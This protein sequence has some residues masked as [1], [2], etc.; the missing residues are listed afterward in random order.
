MLDTTH[1]KANEWV[2]NPSKVNTGL[3]LALEAVRVRAG[4]PIHIH[5]AWDD[6]GHA[7]HSYHYKGM[8]VDF[9][10]DQSLSKAEQLEAVLSVPEIVGIGYYPEW[11]HPGWHVDIR[12]GERLFWVQRKGQYH[13]TKSI[14]EFKGMM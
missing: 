3:I 2:K 13:Y 7:T 10:F 11:A 4:V 14:S 9:H 6:G 8:A 1:F 12:E 5:V